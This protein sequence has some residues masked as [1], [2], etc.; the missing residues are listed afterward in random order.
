MMR[1]ALF[2]LGVSVLLAQS[3]PA[4]DDPIT[5]KLDKAKAAYDEQLDKLRD[6]LVKSLEEKEETA[7][8]SGNKKLVDQ[9]KAEREAFEVRGELPKSVPTGN[10][11]RDTKSART[12]LELAYTAA[13]KEY[14][15]AKKDDEAAAAERDLAAFKDATGDS[16]VS[17]SALLAKDSVWSGVRRVATAKGKIAESPFQLRVTSRDGK[18]FSGVITLDKGRKYDVV[19]NVE[20]DKLGMTTQKKD[21]FKNTFDGRLRG[22]V[23]EMVFSGTGSGGDEVKGIVVLTPAKK[24]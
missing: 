2:A 8:K 21:K 13:I 15:K 4:A 14:V 18:A 5:V 22:R 10:Y 19:G 3:S 9:L 17:L 16:G 12:T 24:K 11:L 23:L 1:T 7:R 6:G 20:G